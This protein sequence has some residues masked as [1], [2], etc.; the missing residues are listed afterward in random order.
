MARGGQFNIVCKYLPMV[1]FLDPKPFRVTDLKAG[2]LKN[3]SFRIHKFEFLF[4]GKRVSSSTSRRWLKDMNKNCNIGQY[5]KKCYS[6]RKIYHFLLYIYPKPNSLNIVGLSSIAP[7]PICR[8][9]YIYISNNKYMH[10]D[11]F[12]LQ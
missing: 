6:Q 1:R 3:S 10:T 8:P 11:I 12:Q 4:L 9:V 7:P 2:H 5:Q